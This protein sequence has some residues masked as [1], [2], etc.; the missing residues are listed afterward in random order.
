MPPGEHP[1]GLEIQPTI[2]AF[3]LAVDFFGEA[4][5]S[6][7]YR[8]KRTRR[9]VVIQEIFGGGRNGGPK[10]H[11]HDTSWLYGQADN[12]VVGT[13]RHD[14]LEFMHYRFF[15]CIVKK[16]LSVGTIPTSFSALKARV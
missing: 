8:K 15:T 10:T 2:W 7:I 13:L 3:Q 14:L 6:G 11:C 5:G 9:A 4:H 1:L 16:R 12:L